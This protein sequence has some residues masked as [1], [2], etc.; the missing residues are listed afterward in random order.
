VS[1]LLACTEVL[2][3]HVVKR[4]R[5]RCVAFGVSVPVYVRG[6]G[7]GMDVGA[8]A[9]E[10]STLSVVFLASAEVSSAHVV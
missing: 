8:A 10:L 7:T 4:P 2:S 6:L 3:A 5:G 1:F 9:S